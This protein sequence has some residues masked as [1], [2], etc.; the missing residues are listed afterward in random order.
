MTTRVEFNNFGRLRA[1]LMRGGGPLVR[2][3]ALDIQSNAQDFAP[4]DTGNLKGS[5]QAHESDSPLTYTVGT[6][7]EYAP[8]QE[9]GTATQSG[10]AFMRPAVEKVRPRFIEAWAQFL[11]RLR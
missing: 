6:P 10:T 3:A 7:V 5:I 9:Y 1:E 2:K 11:G 8:H 4:V